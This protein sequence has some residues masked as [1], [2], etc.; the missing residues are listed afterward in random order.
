MEMVC[1]LAA[2]EDSDAYLGILVVIYFLKYKK[3]PKSVYT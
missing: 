3:T 1:A 2:F